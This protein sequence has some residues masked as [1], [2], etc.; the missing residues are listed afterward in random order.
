M[1]ATARDWG[2]SRSD[3]GLGTRN[4]CVIIQIN[5]GVHLIEAVPSAKDG[6]AALQ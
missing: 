2:G 5:V 3:D 1:R 4:Q 6:Q